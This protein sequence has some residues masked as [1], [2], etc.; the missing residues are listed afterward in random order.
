LCAG[1]PGSAVD[2][3]TETCPLRSYRLGGDLARVG[4]TVPPWYVAKRAENS[5]KKK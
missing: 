2:G 5:G 3:S 1:V 4:A